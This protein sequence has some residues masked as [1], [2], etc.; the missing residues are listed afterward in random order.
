[1]LLT[2]GHAPLLAQRRLQDEN[3]E[4]DRAQKMQHMSAEDAA[5]VWIN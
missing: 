4:G 5:H 2:H 3:D 1:M